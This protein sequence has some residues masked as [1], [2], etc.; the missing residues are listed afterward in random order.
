MTRGRHPVEGVNLS[1]ARHMLSCNRKHQRSVPGVDRAVHGIISSRL[2]LSGVWRDA[3]RTKVVAVGE[4]P[5]GGIRW[6]DFR[7][8]A[9]M[10]HAGTRAG[11]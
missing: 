10:R 11:S 6:G 5:Q 1:H 9:P 4:G 8:L 7:V 3:P 2:P